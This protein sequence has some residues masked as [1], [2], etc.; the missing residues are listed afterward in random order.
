MD[1]STQASLSITNSRSLLK[2]MSIESVMPSTHLILCCPI[3]PSIRVFSNESAVHIMDLDRK[4]EMDSSQWTMKAEQ[5]RGCL[6]WMH[7][8][9]ASPGAMQPTEKRADFEKE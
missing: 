4:R 5:G 3:F 9:L 1:C 8:S 6:S 2:L 7:I